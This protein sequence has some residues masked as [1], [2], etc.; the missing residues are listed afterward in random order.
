[1]LA[2]RSA[3]R[4]LRWARPIPRPAPVTTATRS[5]KLCLST[6]DLSRCVPTSHYGSGSRLDAGASNVGRPVLV[7]RPNRRHHP[8][9]PR[10]ATGSIAR[11][12]SASRPPSIAWRMIPRSGPG[13]CPRTPGSAAPRLL[14]RCR[15]RGHPGDGIGGDARH[16][17]GRV[18]RVRVPRAD[19][20]DRGRR[21]R[22][23][24]RGRLPRDHRLTADI[25]VATSRSAF[26]LAEVRHNLIA[27]AGGLYRLPRDQVGCRDGC[28][29]DRG[30][31]R[32][33]A[34][35][36]STSA[37][38]AGSSNPAPRSTGRSSSRGQIVSAAP[39]A[40][41]ASRRVVLLGRGPSTTTR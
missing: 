34:Q 17:A 7:L 1:M 20:A 39:L 31:D 24:D 21:R 11:W 23:G 33:S 36:V 25:V 40:V 5:S 37:W 6:H 12:R 14:R 16:R 4:N 22:S 27:A 8:Q 38:S 35:Q 9:P 32:R 26:G 10:H 13:S 2:P 19:E 28:H 15:P 41:R 29:P 3:R 30:A 18:R